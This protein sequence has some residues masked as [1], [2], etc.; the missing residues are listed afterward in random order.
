MLHTFLVEFSEFD[1]ERY[2]LSIPGRIPVSSFPDF[3]V[4]K[5]KSEGSPP[6]LSEE[7][8]Q[9]ILERYGSPSVSARAGSTGDSREFVPKFF[10]IMVWN[11]AVQTCG[12][13]KGPQVSIP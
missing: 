11:L 2:C 4:L 3:T 5:A 6:L 9:A 12:R 8:I 1:W 10:N 13:G 7:R